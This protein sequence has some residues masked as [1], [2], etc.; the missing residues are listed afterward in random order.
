MPLGSGG[1]GHPDDR[2]PLDPGFHDRVLPEGGAG[3]KWV[4]YVP[5]RYDPQRAWPLIVFLHGRGEEGSDGRVQTTV[6]LGPAIGRD[7]DRW[8]AIVV[9][10]QKP[11]DRDGWDAYEPRVLAA[12]MAARHETRVDPD[13]ITLTGVSMGGFGAWLMAPRRPDLFAAIAPVCGGGDP[14]DAPDLAALPIWA[15]HGTDDPV[16]PVEHTTRMV[17]AVRRA[18]GDPRLTLYEGV[19]HD[20]WDRAYAEPELPEWLLSQRLP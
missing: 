11:A 7:P 5:P 10:P 19:G 9:F 12:L 6:G 16:V 2:A 4:L 8:P 13:R 18:G 20:S 15:F 14:A 17:E 3:S 1:A